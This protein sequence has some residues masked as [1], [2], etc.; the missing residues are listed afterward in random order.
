[1]SKQLATVLGQYFARGVDTG[2]MAMSLAVV[3]SM[4]NVLPEYI[5]EDKLN[6]VFKKME[7]DV[8]E[9]W[10]EATAQ[11]KKND[12]IATLLIG[13]AEEIRKKRGLEALE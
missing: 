7:D 3:I 10:G 4:E 5:D 9:V 6:E 13:H 8:R 2:A 1:M 12:D 11:S